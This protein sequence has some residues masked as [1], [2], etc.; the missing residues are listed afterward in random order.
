MG[1]NYDFDVFP[2]VD[3]GDAAVAC[4]RDPRT[5]VALCRAP[6][7][8]RECFR[9]AGFS[10]EA[11][12]SGAPP[13]G[14]PEADGAQRAAVLLRLAEVLPLAR[15]AQGEPEQEAPSAFRLDAFLAAAAAARPMAPEPAPEVPPAPE[16]PAPVWP[17]LL[18]V[19]S[20]AGSA[21]FLLWQ[22]AEA[23]QLIAVAGM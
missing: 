18:V 12:S 4:F 23:A 5:L 1:L 2:A 8:L 17:R 9:L 11:R 10:P 16:A 20:I 14:F 6:R 22:L 7:A 15:I 13:G 19:A 21:A 3:K